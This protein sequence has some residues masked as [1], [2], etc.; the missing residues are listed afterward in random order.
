MTSDYINQ[1]AVGFKIPGEANR[2]VYCIDMLGA[3]PDFDYTPVYAAD[4]TDGELCECGCDRTWHTSTSSWV[5]NQQPFTVLGALH[6]SDDHADLDIVPADEIESTEQFVR[7]YA[8][9]DGTAF[10]WYKIYRTECG[11]DVAVES[12][13]PAHTLTDV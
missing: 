1:G 2:G 4:M 8:K 6:V 11:V 5:G 3:D 9:R 13:S 7:Y 12:P 10:T